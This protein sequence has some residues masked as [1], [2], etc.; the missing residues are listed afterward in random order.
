[1]VF[2]IILRESMEEKGASINDIAML[3]C[4]DIS[5]INKWLNGV[6]APNKVILQMLGDYLK[7][8]EKFFLRPNV[9]YP[10]AMR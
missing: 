6:Q 9:S 7:N 5:T 10:S 1:M 2:H 3:T 4:R 8:D